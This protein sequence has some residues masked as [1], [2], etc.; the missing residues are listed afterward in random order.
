MKVKLLSPFE[1]GEQIWIGLD[2]PGMR[3]KVFRLVSPEMG[4]EE[5]MAGV[6][7]F[8]PGESSSMHH[9]AESEEINIVLAGGGTLVSEG[10]ERQFVT[11]EMMWIPRGHVPPAPQHRQ[12]APSTR[13]DLHA[14]GGTAHDVALLRRRPDRSTGV[15]GRRPSQVVSRAVPCSVRID[16]G[17]NWIPSTGCW[18]W[19]I[20]ITSPSGDQAVSSS[21]SGNESRATAS[22][23]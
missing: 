21:A 14:A 18:R 9:H 17:W 2:T 23:W 11:G 12:G 4:S 8:E 5:F 13:L 22:E 7:V 19:R 10:E 15:Y 3:R 6:T 16:S 20:P 1:D